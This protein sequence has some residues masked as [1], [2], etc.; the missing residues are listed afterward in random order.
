MLVTAPAMTFLSSTFF[1]LSLSELFGLV[2]RACPAFDS[3]Q[4][5]MISIGS[6]DLFRN[7]LNL[8]WIRLAVILIIFPVVAVAL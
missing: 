6:N 7:K 5:A 2:A 3:F 8:W 4:S 1:V